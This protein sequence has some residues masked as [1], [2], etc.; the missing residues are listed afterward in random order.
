[1]FELLVDGHIL[2]AVGK[3]LI[4]EVLCEEVVLDLD[5]SLIAKLLDFTLKVVVLLFKLFDVFVLD[6]EGALDGV[7]LFLLLANLLFMLLIK[8]LHLGLLLREVKLGVFDLLYQ[9]IIVHLLLELTLC[10]LQ[11][12]LQLDFFCL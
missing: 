7:E 11:L 1:M 8:C 12:V 5:E 6:L 2:F 3:A 9:I 4:V 10:G